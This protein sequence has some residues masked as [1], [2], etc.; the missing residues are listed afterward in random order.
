MGALHEIRK[1]RTFFRCSYANI[2]VQKMPAAFSAQQIFSYYFY[3]W[4]YLYVLQVYIC[5]QG[6]I[7]FIV[8]RFWC[9]IIT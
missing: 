3:I 6:F 1:V 8:W 7:L 5:L 4:K 2:F 9:Q